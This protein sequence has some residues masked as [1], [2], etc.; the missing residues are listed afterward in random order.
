MVFG[1]EIM[2]ADKNEK[3]T[4]RDL[5]VWRK[6]VDLAKVIYRMTQAMPNEERFGLTT[7]M[8]RAAVSI[9]SNIAEGNA[10][11]T[12]S[13]YLHFLAI[14]RGSLAE[15][16]TQILIAQELDMIK[17]TDQASSLLAEV[18]RM[19]Q[20]LIRSLQEKRSRLKSS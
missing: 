2:M 8:R 17:Q 7:Q 13:D 15:L 6:S 12:L 4:F 3:K 19:L 20:A 1:K 16:E 5:I 9:P 14:A 11:Q 10:R 18:D